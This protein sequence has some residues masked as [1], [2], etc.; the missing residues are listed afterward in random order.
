[1]RLFHFSERGDIRAFH[2]RPVETPS[3]RKPGMEWLNGPLVWAIDAWHQPLYLFPRDC[4]RIVVWSVEGSTPRDWTA[5]CGGSAARMVAF[6]ERE[7]S[8]SVSR[9]AIHRYQLPP[10]K[11][12]SLDD[13]GMWVSASTVDPLAVELIGDLPAALQAQDVDLRAVDDLGA[14]RGIWSSTLHA[15]GIRLRNARTW[16]PA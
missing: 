3:G 8:A 10:E 7:W 1:M 9:G 16:S 11:F 6:V 12:R 2:P 5:W 13:A 14:L 4:P 15:S